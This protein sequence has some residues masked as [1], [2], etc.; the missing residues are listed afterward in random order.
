MIRPWV[1]NL[2]GQTNNLLHGFKLLVLGESAHSQEDAIGS[3]PEDYI[4]T[5]VRMVLGGSRWKFY[6]KIT[7]LLADKPAHNLQPADFDQVW[8]SIAFFNYVPVIA[9][10]GPEA[11]PTEEMFARGA[12]PLLDFIT[13]KQPDGILVCGK[14]NWWHVLSGAGLDPKK[15]EYWA[16]PVS[17]HGTPATFIKHPSSSFNATHWRSAVD[18]LLARTLA[19]P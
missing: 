1:G 9:A 17:I 15:D 8:E 14:E 10:S 6:N 16:Q 13:D 7:A 3:E 18:N 19:S 12:S 2:W 4:I 11:R 5:T